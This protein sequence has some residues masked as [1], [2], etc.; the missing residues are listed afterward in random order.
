MRA[1]VIE[2]PGGPDVLRLGDL[3]DPV[4]G[5]GE[6]L[7]R[8]RATALNRL[9]L[10]QRQ[11]NYP[12]PPGASDILGVE[13]AGEVIG[14]ADD[15]AGWSVGD[16]VFALLLSGGYA[17]MA[18]VPAGMAMSIPDNLSFEQ[19]AAIPEVFLTAY[20]NLFV[21]GQLPERGYALIH[22]GA[23]GIGTAAIQ[24]VREHGAAAI[25]TVGS[26][27]KAERCL[28]LGAI[29]AVNYHEVSFDVVVTRVTGGRGVDVVL[30]MVGGPYW[31]RNLAS[32]TIGGRLILVAA[33]GGAK[34]EIHL[35]AIQSKRLRI[36]GSMLRPL[37]LAEKVSLTEQFETYALERFADGRLVPVVD[38][39]YD[40]RDAP[41]AHRYMESN[42]NIG[43]IVLRVP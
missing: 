26:A 31:T 2:Q 28:Q 37:P 4:P 11:G 42:A 10:Y 29:A 20:L 36:I 22:A 43:K 33:Q 13:M 41:A 3:P 1:I 30:D 34:L 19:A 25:V 35:G 38:S 24:L 9:D 21:I 16:R 14:W 39:V 17:E 7:V 23:S 8:I 12:V 6:L 15:V 27:V 5:P 18:A 32:L 40:L